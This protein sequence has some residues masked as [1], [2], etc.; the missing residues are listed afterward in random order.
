[1]ERPPPSV[2][3]DTFEVLTEMLGYD[4]DFVGALLVRGALD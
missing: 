4:P 1:V 2:G 3:Q